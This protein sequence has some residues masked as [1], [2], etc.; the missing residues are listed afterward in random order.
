MSIDIVPAAD[1]VALVQGLGR[2]GEAP[3]VRWFAA[4]GEQALSYA[5]LARRLDAAAAR[6]AAH[7]VV[8]GARVLLLAD[9]GL[10]WALA[11]LAVL[12][13]GGV[14]LPLDAHAGDEALQHAL[15]DAAPALVL[16]DAA[17]APRC[18][19]GVS[20]LLLIDS[21]LGADHGASTSPAP[22]VI[23]PAAPAVMFYTSGTTGAPKGVPLSHANLL[24]QLR[25]VAALELARPGDRVL[26]P[27]PMHHVY[28][29]VIGLLLPLAAGL[30]L[31]LPGATTGAQIMQALRDGQASV[32]IGVP[33]L[34]RALLEG[35][36]ARLAALPPLSARLMRG[37]RALARR[38]APRF[39]PG[40]ARRLL[41]PLHRQLAPDLRL[42]AC[43][44]AA[45]E[46]DLD[47]ALAALGWQV[48]VGYGLTE[49]S[50]LLTLRLPGQCRPGSAGRAVPGT[51]LR[52]AP[53]QAGDEDLP[54]GAG[55]IEVR[56]PGVFAGYFGP[57]EA[58]RQAF[59]AD[60]W[61]RTGDLGRFD[62]DGCLEVLGRAST[63]IV[64]ESGKN[65][66][67][68]EVEAVNQAHPLIAEAAV[69]Q[70]D[71]KLVAL[72]V[73]APQLPADDPAQTL[74]RL[75]AALA[76]QSQR[77]PSYQRVVEF[78]V[79]RQPLERTAL[80]KLRRHLLAQRYRQARA[81]LA[82]E[83]VPA[84]LA[85]ADEA[86]LRDPRARAVWE[87]LAERYPDRAL[88]PDSHLQLDLGLDSLAW[89]NVG[90][91]IAAR[92]GA[93]LSEDAIARIATVRDLLREVSLAGTAPPAR[94]LDDPRAAL[95]AEQ[96]RWLEPLPRGL[97]PLR[98]LL[99]ALDWLLMRLVFRLHVTGRERL[100]AKGAFLLA[101]NHA[102][103]LDAPALAAA[104]GRRALGSLCW[105][106]WSG[107]MLANPA[108]RLVSRLARVLPMDPDRRPLSSLAL[109]LAA[110]RAGNALVWFPEGARSR[111]GALGPFR[112]GIGLLL[113]HTDVPVLPVYI[114][115][116]Y[117][118]WP[119]HRRWPR[120][121]RL[122]VHFGTPIAA[123]RLLA[124]GGAGPP[125]ERATHALREAML[126]LIR[127]CETA[128]QG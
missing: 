13:A 35:I 19:G 42:L 46:A 68:E 123:S 50:P 70:V 41:A 57:P 21:L 77:L 23:D 96:R 84:P 105:A 30:T 45:L 47:V 94:L 51:L 113:E 48:A 109:G 65:I 102:S 103:Y 124:S 107:I 64:T 60:G 116:S 73:P 7:G 4:G 14:L 128:Q 55:E 2:F 6:L 66:Q 33:R 75:R 5:A 95:D 97:W 58:N 34:Y 117:R 20:P 82:G 112:P 81:A 71:R 40:A 59:T 62:A 25:T 122:G 63:L 3:A 11:A 125:H 92:C 39:G 100:P 86:L 18:A 49:T 89:L 76:E 90:M 106:G 115:G 120:P 37:L 119:V 101:P 93:Q 8:P 111:S 16:T 15:A 32:L 121:A 52:L 67:P 85:A 28:P 118:A 83:A 10:P 69:L 24:Y 91:D 78:A 80:G 79:T 38:L 99:W 126:E 26:L 12:R 56:G 9:S 27:L 110:L 108:M 114:E 29:F 74:A 87:Y 22:A 98:A 72:L 1:L 88:T 53:P 36:D 61:F 54:Q 44:G 104:L 17:Q 31:L 43:G 127:A